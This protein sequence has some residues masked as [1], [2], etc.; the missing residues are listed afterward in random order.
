MIPGS[1]L[2]RTVLFRADVSVSMGTGHAMRC[3]ALAQAWQ[4]AGG[5]AVFAMAESTAAVFEMLRTEGLE[6]LS[7]PAEAG[8][9]DDSRQTASLALEQRAAWVVVDGYQFGADF[10][11]AL[12]T[13]GLRIL[14]LDDNGHAGSYSADLVLNQ[15]AH[16]AENMYGRREPYTQLLLGTSYSLLRREFSAWKD[17][18]REIPETGRKVLVT[19]GGSDPGNFTAMVMQAIQQ[20]KIPGLETVVV[21]GASNPHFASLEKIAPDPDRAI[22]L[23]RNV[24]DMAKLMTWAD[25]AVSAAG[26]TCLEMC[27]LGLPA[28]VVAVAENQRAAA[29]ELENRN[30]VVQLNTQS[31]GAERVAESIERLLQDRQTRQSLSQRGRELVDGDGAN[32]VISAIENASPRW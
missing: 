31:L 9:D 13:A 17:R 16:A 32:R 4:D 15:N 11:R 8:S 6:V 29:A 12:K 30:C 24:S 28:I 5:R 19:F 7:V 27:L 18:R 14:F 23:E 22:R 26:T 1:T 20:V 2:S 3:L 10:Q 21:I 25:L